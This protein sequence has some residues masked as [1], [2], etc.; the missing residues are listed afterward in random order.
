MGGARRHR[1]GAAA[2]AACARLR[3]DGVEV[4][5][6]AADV[7]DEAALRGA[8]AA[9][10]RPI[11]GVAHCAGIV[12]D[13]TLDALD[14]AAFAETLRAKVGGAV[15]LDRLTEAEPLDFFLLYSSI[16]AAVGRHG[17]AAYAAANGYLDALAQRRRLRARP[18]LSIGWGSWAAGMGA[19]DAKTAERIRAGGLN[20]LSEGEA[21]AALERA[22]TGEPHLVV[23]AID[24]ARIA[25]QPDLP[26]LIEGLVGRAPAANA[27]TLS[28]DQLRGRPAGERRARVADYLDAELRA[29]LSSPAALPRQTSLLD[30]GVD[31]L[32]GAELR[33]AL[34]RALGVS[35]AISH[36]IDG[37]SLDELIDQVM[38]QLERKL[39]TEQHSAAGADTEEITL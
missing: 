27:R 16:S 10:G 3:G 29:V 7:A 37:S 39:V 30:L 28:F 21:F 34:E 6:A 17:Q 19:A 38:A 31:S 20:P 25:A 15:L 2:Q 8:L 11:R 9:A 32:T 5:V 33:N 26:P 12:R 1:A 18:A 36:L 4:R 22:F 23:A 14:A 24:L 35:V 13:A